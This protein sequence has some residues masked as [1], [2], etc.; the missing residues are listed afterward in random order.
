LP[1]GKIIPI[2]LAPAS[3]RQLGQ[4]IADSDMLRPK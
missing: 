2:R 3:H 4:R 1:S